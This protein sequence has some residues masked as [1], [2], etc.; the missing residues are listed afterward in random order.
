MN[1]ID[2]HIE[3]IQSQM[4]KGSLE[5]CVLLVLAKGE[6]YPLEILKELKEAQMMVVEGTLYPLLNRMKRE[7]LLD[8]AWQESQS[9]PPRKYYRL[10]D[11]G[12]E[13]LERQKKVWLVFS[14]SIDT[15]MKGQIK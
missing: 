1:I 5:F 8:Y 6:M 14:H 15:L 12:K 11:K 4:R 13:L 2:E 7:E 10:T 3:N 9:G